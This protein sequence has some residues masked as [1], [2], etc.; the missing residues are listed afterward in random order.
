MRSKEAGNGQAEILVRSMGRMDSH[1]RRI[2]WLQPE[3][4]QDSNL[5][6]PSPQ[7]SESWYNPKGV[8]GD[9][10]NVEPKGEVGGASGRP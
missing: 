5:L 6:T 7:T 2:G 9:P 8:E 3:R 10:K 1:A 4:C